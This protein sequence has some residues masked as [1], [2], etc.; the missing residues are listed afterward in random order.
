MASNKV[1]EMMV[2]CM[3][4]D[5]GA[6]ATARATY[7]AMQPGDQALMKM[8][9]TRV[10]Q[11]PISVLSPAQR[12]QMGYPMPPQIRPGSHAPAGGRVLT[13]EQARARLKELTT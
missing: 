11:E 12:Q 7:A 9:F 3:R 10:L 6:I 4:G 2:S 1:Q 5:A 8:V 13:P